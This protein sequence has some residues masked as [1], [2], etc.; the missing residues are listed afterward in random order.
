MRLS[1]LFHCRMFQWNDIFVT[2]DCKHGPCKFLSVMTRQIGSNV[3]CPMAAISDFLT[4]P[5]SLEAKLRS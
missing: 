2:N 1:S 3:W 5:E 4:S